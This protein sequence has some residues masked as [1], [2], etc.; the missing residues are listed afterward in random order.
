MEDAKPKKL[1]IAVLLSGGGTTMLN[2]A[3]RIAD[4][5]LPA[6]IRLVVASNRAA[7]GIAR[8]ERLGLPVRVV[9]RKEFTS[10]ELFSK[11]I[12]AH[13]RDA[14]VELVCLAGFLSLLTIP[15]DYER[16][17][18]NIHPSLLP[19]FGGKGMHGRAVHE[20][21]LAAGEAESGCTVHFADNTYDTGPVILQ[22]RC[23]VLP[24]DTPEALAAR[25]FEQECVA[26]PEA[27]AGFAADWVSDSPPSGRG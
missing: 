8:A 20:A 6:E 13:L 7:K 17:V 22:R 23:P 18:M 5:A 24:G 25:V 15:E 16:R 9:P 26:Y 12:F 19:K 1:P 21:V 2:L 11:F 27:V 10:G 4:G 14:G 3:G